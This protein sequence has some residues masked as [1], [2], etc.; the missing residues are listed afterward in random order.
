MTF[1][2]EPSRH[3]KYFDTSKFRQCPVYN[4]SH[5]L[6]VTMTF[7]PACIPD[8]LVVVVCLADVDLVRALHLHPHLGLLI[9][10][11]RNVEPV[12]E[13]NKRN[14]INFV[15]KRSKYRVGYIIICN[16]WLNSSVGRAW[17]E[18]LS[19]HCL[20]ARDPKVPGSNPK[21][22]WLSFIIN[23]VV[24]C[25]KKC[26]NVFSFGYQSLIICKCDDDILALLFWWQVKFVKILNT[27]SLPIM[28]HLYNIAY[29][30]IP[31]CNTYPKDPRTSFWSVLQESSSQFSCSSL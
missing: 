23:N 4:R 25:W 18:P 13:K 21:Y 7:I 24:G 14:I 16:I 29:K 22:H 17:N 11:W 30:C 31:G 1:I 6:F 3:T 15:M 26:Y 19:C 5:R 20:R 2:H 28:S 8:L 10:T 27:F 12:D 9:H